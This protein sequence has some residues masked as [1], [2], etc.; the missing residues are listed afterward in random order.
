MLLGFLSFEGFPNEK[1]CV[2]VCWCDECVITAL[3]ICL[4]LSANFKVYAN[5][6][7]STVNHLNIIDW[8]YKLELECHHWWSLVN[9]RTSKKSVQF[10][11]SDNSTS[12]DSMMIDISSSIINEAIDEQVNVKISPVNMSTQ[13]NHEKVKKVQLIRVPSQ[14]PNHKTRG[15]QESM[16]QY[17][18]SP[19]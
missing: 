8:N 18:R 4:C 6:E 1:S 11:F 10:L 17:Q 13:V 7:N 14:H 3:L 16:H 12:T 9:E 15:M 2:H 5:A 19:N